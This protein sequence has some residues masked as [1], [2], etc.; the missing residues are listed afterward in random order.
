MLNVLTFALKVSNNAQVTDAEYFTA[1]K[2]H[3]FSEEVILGIT[4]ITPCFGLS[5]SRC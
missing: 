1:L 2:S 5:Y 4:A 3:D